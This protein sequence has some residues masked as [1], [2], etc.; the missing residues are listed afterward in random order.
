MI[1]IVILDDTPQSAVD[2]REQ[3]ERLLPEGLPHRIATLTR[4][5]SLRALL[6]ARERIDLLITDIIMPAGQ[7]SGIDIVRNLFPQGTGTQVIYVSGY[8]EQSLEVY[9]TNHLYF[10]LKPVED[11]RLKEALDLALSAIERNQPSML[12]IKYGHK[13]QLINTATISYLSSNLRKVTVHCKAGQLE[14]YA[15]LD[16]LMP[17]LPDGFVRCHRSYVANLAY[18]V[19]LQ[20]D[21]IQLNDGTTL[22]VSRRRAKEV[23]HALL[24][25]ISGRQKNARPN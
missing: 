8:L 1:S 22:P 18:A 13:E 11:A 5:D 12:R 24:A 16:D 23:Q 10:L 15:K 9:P 17:Q 25:H 2:L 7:P 20:E 4:L 6:T 21:S 3:V 19:S 14:T